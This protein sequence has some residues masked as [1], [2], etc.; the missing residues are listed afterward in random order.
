MNAI[1]NAVKVAKVYKQYR[2]NGYTA[3]NALREARVRVKWAELEDDKV[4]L[5]ILPDEMCDI[6][7]LKGDTFNPKANP[8]VPVSRL[9]REEREFEGRVNSDGV[10]GIMGEY[11]CPCCG[12][13]ITADS[14]W[15]FVGDDWKNSGYD[16]D[17][18]YS[19]MIELGVAEVRHMAG[20]THK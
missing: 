2:R 18:M 4:R 19:T 8:D 17:V 11:K 9:E 3:E 15:G 7:N 16:S 6:D 20:Q 10:W 12:Q 13:W 1:S 5:Q 14:V